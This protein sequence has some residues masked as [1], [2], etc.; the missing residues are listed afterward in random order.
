M[1]SVATT[2]SGDYGGSGSIADKIGH[3]NILWVVLGVCGAL[4]ILFGI[5]MLT[6]GACA[7]QRERQ[8]EFGHK[9]S[10]SV[11]TSADPDEE[12]PLIGRVLRSQAGSS[13]RSSNGSVHA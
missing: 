3:L 4:I 13:Q 12:R 8:N 1:K 7:S 5:F 10:S 2:S 9:T 11:S 6:L